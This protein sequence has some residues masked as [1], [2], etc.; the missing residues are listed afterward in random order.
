MMWHIFKNGWEDKEF[1]R[2]RVY[3]MDQV[4][5]EVEK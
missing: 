5:K 4:R 2:Q 3:G 1:I